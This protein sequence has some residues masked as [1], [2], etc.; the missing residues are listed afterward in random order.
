[1]QLWLGGCG[2]AVWYVGS[3]LESDFVAGA[4]VGLMIAALTLRFLR[5]GTETGGAE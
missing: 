1:M 3:V 5:K 2:A 4:G